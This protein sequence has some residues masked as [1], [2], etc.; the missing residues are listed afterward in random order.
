[1]NTL[2]RDEVLQVTGF[3]SLSGANAGLFRELVRA[4][5]A[6]QHRR[7]EVDMSRAAFMD[8]EGLGALVA[9]RARLKE[10]GGRVELV[11]TPSQVR[12][13]LRLTGVDSLFEFL[14]SP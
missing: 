10:R 6:P 11:G 8:S 4:K 14:P 7:V 5:L 3:D 12:E 9:I 1:M 13:L 2:T